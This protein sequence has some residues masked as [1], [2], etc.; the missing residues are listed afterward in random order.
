L[1]W[2]VTVPLPRA[3]IVGVAMGDK[4]ETEVEATDG[5]EVVLLP[6]GVTMKV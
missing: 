1:K 5:V 4:V 3:A 2:T 6:V